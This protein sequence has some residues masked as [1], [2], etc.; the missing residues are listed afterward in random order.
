MINNYPT[1]L[2]INRANLLEA[3]KRRFIVQ[4]EAMLEFDTELDL[5]QPNEATFFF[6][7]CE[8]KQ[9]FLPIEEYA[10]NGEKIISQMIGYDGKN[11]VWI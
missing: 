7:D 4:Q 5:R 2:L 6:G 1:S 9:V 11:E 10:S 3:K 8:G